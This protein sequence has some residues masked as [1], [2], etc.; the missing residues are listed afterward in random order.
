LQALETTPK[1]ESI[2][3][4][5]AGALSTKYKLALSAVRVL[6]NTG[7]INSGEIPFLEDALRDPQNISQFLNPNS[8]ATITGQINALADFLESKNE[9]NDRLFG[10]DVAPLRGSEIRK[11]K[12]VPAAAAA[13]GI[14]QQEWDNSTDEEKKPWR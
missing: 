4:E 5:K 14:T 6:Q 13:A 12:R 10:Y 1:E 2:T 9:N 11:A 8:R 3:G 7:V